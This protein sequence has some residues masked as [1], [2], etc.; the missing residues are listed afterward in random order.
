[1]VSFLVYDLIFLAIFLVFFSSFLYS[2]RKNLKKEG[3]LVLYKTSWGINLINYLETK[4]R[5]TLKALS[6]IS[7]LTGYALMA[8]V[9]YMIYIIVK[10]YIFSPEIVR[11][12]KVPPILPLVPYV[13]RLVPNI[14][15]PFYFTYWI[16]IIAVIAITHE[17]AHGILM[18]RYNVKIKST[19]FAFFPW[20]FPIFPAAFVEQDEKSMNKSTKFHQLSILSAG[21]FAN[22][23]T[24]ILFLLVLFGFFSVAFSASGVV[25]DT[26]ATSAITIS[27][28]S[29][30]NGVPISN[31]SYEKV[32]GLS[33]EEG[34]NE[35]V[36]ANEN[37]LATKDILE[38]QDENNG[39]IF[40]YNDAPAIRANLSGIITEING[41]KIKDID[42]LV[43]EISKYSPGDK[44]TI[45]EKTDTGFSDKEIILEEHPN[46]PG[47]TWL[48]IGFFSKKSG[49]FF[50]RLVG[51]IASFRDKNIY[52]EP[53]IDGISVFI[54]NLLWW[55]VIISISVALINML[56]VGIF[57]GG[58]FFYLTV[59]EI[60]K[61]EN[62]AKKAF[63][64]STYLFL[65]LLLLLMVF[66]L[67]SFW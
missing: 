37:Y 15:P 50:G 57:D 60:T 67:F 33:K 3:L 34:F 58:R 30:V 45:T 7:I 54:Y 20:F 53:K 61:N 49:G 44:V 27:G 6:Y 19:G 64:F 36:S 63:A 40:V 41:V 21:T 26:Y 1:M 17:V 52:Y 25:F 2:K 23:I 22:I 62:V 24:G 56:P 65:F 9:L 59:L 51:K 8:G 18:R 47:N 29:M 5:R 48:G 10:I 16:I 42:G 13:D 46:K 14:L 12:I 32:L 66:W 35:I 43:E 31:P 11:A 39:S 4:F 28:I 38:S 55:V